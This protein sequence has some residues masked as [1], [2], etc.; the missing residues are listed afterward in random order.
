MSPLASADANSMRLH[1]SLEWK[2][3]QDYLAE[4]GFQLEIIRMLPLDQ[5]K[6]IMIDACTHVSLKLAEMES[7]ARFIEKLHSR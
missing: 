7:R 2:Y 5:A 4:R 6:R 3:L 1:S